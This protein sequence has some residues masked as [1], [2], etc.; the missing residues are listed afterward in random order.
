MMYYIELIDRFWLFV[1]KTKPGT[2]AISLY[3]YL[4]Q[5]VKQKVAYQFT[6]SDIELAKRLGI[7]RATVKATRE[8]LSKFGLIEYQSLQ[9]IAGIYRLVVNYPLEPISFDKVH[10]EPVSGI[11]DC[12]GRNENVLES[13]EI[14][15]KD[16]SAVTVDE[17]IP[18]EPTSLLIDGRVVPGPEE[19]LDYARTLDAYH[20]KLDDQIMAKHSVWLQSNWRNAS[21]RP[22]TNWQSSLKNVLP[23]LTSEVAQ[24]ELTVHNIPEIIHPKEQ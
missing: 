1:E 10:N 19:F 12:F 4:L 14:D 17:N 11:I 8:K 2:A 18:L 13:K 24:N 3:L 20:I 15:E 21:G 23:F 16:N 5:V 7:N 6:I 22:I 9:G